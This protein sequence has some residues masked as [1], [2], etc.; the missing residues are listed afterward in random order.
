M[1]DTLL[2]PDDT[3][4]IPRPVGET[5]TRI[6]TGEQTRKGARRDHGRDRPP[7]PLR[8]APPVAGD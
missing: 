7:A 6:D 2:S 8:S 5:R 3:G 4:E 1:T